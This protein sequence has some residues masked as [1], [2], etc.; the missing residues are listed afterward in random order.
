MNTHDT[1]NKR[2]GK[3][4]SQSPGESRIKKTAL[5]SKSPQ[6]NR[7]S[8]QAISKASRGRR[9]PRKGSLAWMREKYQAH[10]ASICVLCGDTIKPPLDLMTGRPCEGMDPEHMGCNPWPLA[11]EGQCC[12]ECDTWVLAARCGHSIAS[13]LRFVRKMRAATNEAVAKFLADKKGGAA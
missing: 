7:K 1:P 6:A 10:L 4:A 9:P 11:Q 5:S 13:G 3:P 8:P 12:H 2:T